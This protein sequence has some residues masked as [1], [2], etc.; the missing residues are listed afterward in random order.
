M[1]A[2]VV[3]IRLIPTTSDYISERGY[4]KTPSWLGSPD[5]VERICQ[6]NS[7]ANIQTKTVHKLSQ[8]AFENQTAESQFSV[9]EVG[10]G[11]GF[12]QLISDMLIVFREPIFITEVKYNLM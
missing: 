1:T 3:G 9:F 7:A 6:L 8:S 4:T 12:R 10:F 5:A 2:P 11:S